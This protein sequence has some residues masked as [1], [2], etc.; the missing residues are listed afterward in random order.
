MSK[1]IVGATHTAHET[2]H[3]P[4]KMELVRQG[5]LKPEE[6]ESLL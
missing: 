5:K 6:L 4:R 1:Q 3:L 2:R